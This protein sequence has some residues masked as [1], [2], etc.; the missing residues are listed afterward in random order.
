MLIYVNVILDGVHGGKYYYYYYIHDFNSFDERSTNFIHTTKTTTEEMFAKKKRTSS[1]S[2]QQHQPPQKKIRTESYNDVL[3]D[4]SSALD[5]KRIEHYKQQKQLHK[6]QQQKQQK[7]PQQQ[8]VKKVEQV[9]EEQEEEEDRNYELLTSL[10][11]NQELISKVHCDESTLDAHL[12]SHILKGQSIQYQK[13]KKNIDHQLSYIIASMHNLLRVKYEAKHGVGVLVLLPN[14]SAVHALYDRIVNLLPSNFNS[15]LDI[16]SGDISDKIDDNQSE[17]E[18]KPLIYFDL[19]SDSH[20]RPC[21]CN[22]LITTVDVLVR[23]DKLF[24]KNKFQQLRSIICEDYDTFNETNSIAL[25]KRLNGVNKLPKQMILLS[26]FNNDDISWITNNISASTVNRTESSTNKNTTGTTVRIH[27]VD[28][29]HR[30]LELY[31]LIQREAVN[32]HKKVLVLFNDDNTVNMMY[33]LF[34]RIYKERSAKKKKDNEEALAV[35]SLLARSLYKMT[36]DSYYMTEMKSYIMSLQSSVMFAEWNTINAIHMND[37]IELTVIFDT[38]SD[39]NSYQHI[40]LLSNKIVLFVLKYT[41]GEQ[42]ME[43]WN[44]S[45]K[46]KNKKQ[47]QLSSSTNNEEENTRIQ[48]WIQQSL[49]KSKLTQTLIDK[50]LKESFMKHYAATLIEPLIA[51]Y[52]SKDKFTPRQLPLE[53]I[54]AMFGCHTGMSGYYEYIQTLATIVNEHITSSGNKN[55]KQKKIS[56][57][58]PQNSNKK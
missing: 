14:Q 21:D 25:L 49:Q 12:I 43:F 45:I 33:Y 35:P 51:K 39:N 22:L 38:P 6:Q 46:K 37:P 26:H 24:K 31:K 52:G 18:Q 7:Q 57:V 8:E 4:L 54:A 47:Q 20:K 15:L 32:K 9:Q 41:K 5:N 56:D 1:S 58:A 19:K 13:K 27:K 17:K 29:K 50:C 40:Q 42:T 16:G 48:L 3:S 36:N 2:Q 53:D 11:I 55:N 34:T 30:I 10:N 28:L 23:A 44:E